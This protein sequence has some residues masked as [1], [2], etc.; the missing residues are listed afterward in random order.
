MVALVGQGINHVADVPVQRV[1]VFPVYNLSSQTVVDSELE[2][3][4]ERVSVLEDVLHDTLVCSCRHRMEI[5]GVFDFIDVG[6]YRE[7]DV[8]MSVECQ[9]FSVDQQCYSALQDN[10]YKVV[11]GTSWL[12]VSDMSFALDL[13]RKDVLVDVS[14]TGH[15][16]CTEYHCRLRGFLSFVTHFGIFVYKYRYF[17]K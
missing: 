8:R 12:A 17:S 6:P 14:D 16:V 3:R 15:V 4:W 9:T 5:F 2:V 1:N 11:F 10:D 13:A 7:I